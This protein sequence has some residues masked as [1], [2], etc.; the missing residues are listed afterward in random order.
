MLAL[1]Q[2]AERYRPEEHDGAP[3]G[4]Y[5]RMVIRGAMIDS[6]SGPRYRDSMMAEIYSDDMQSA[7]PTLDEDIDAQRTRARLNDAIEYLDPRLRGIIRA[8][9][10][11]GATMKTAARE[12]GLS[13][14]HTHELTHDALKRLRMIMHA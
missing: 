10:S 12:V 11:E 14:S 7:A 9:Y 5:A 1:L 6:V 2:A 4:P 13:K 3:F 8:Y